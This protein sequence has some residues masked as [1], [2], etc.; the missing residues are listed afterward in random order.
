[1]LKKND[2]F[3]AIKEKIKEKYPN[4]TVYSGEVID[5][6]RTPAFFCELVKTAGIDN[7]NTVSNTLSVIITFFSDESKQAV[8]AAIEDE[9][10]E[11]F[12]QG[13]VVGTRF[14]T[15]ETI[16]SVR[17]GEKQYAT[18]I[19]I[20]IEYKDSTGY[21]YNEGLDLMEELHADIKIEK[22]VE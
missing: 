5:G 22:G 11:L 16:S 20:A 6:F 3:A 18:Q 12:Y 1:M 17:L 4:Y 19:T 2:V 7:K 10:E 14:L 13:I 21:D 15:V 8:L 9:I